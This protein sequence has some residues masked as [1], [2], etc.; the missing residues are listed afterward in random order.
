MK[1][2]RLLLAC[3]FAFAFGQML[4]QPNSPCPSPAPSGA[5]SCQDACVYCDLDGYNGV[6]NNPISGGNSP[7]P[8]ILIQND[9]WYGF[10][11]G[12]QTSVRV[13]HGSVIAPVPDP[14]AVPQGLDVVCPG[15]VVEYTIPEVF[16]AGSYTW[17]APPDASINGLGSTLVLEAP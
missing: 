17:T 11:A 8:D 3:L 1:K 5:T 2:E 14:A 9:S 13:S 12:L 15:A 10:T 16:G 4:A 6:S 7:C